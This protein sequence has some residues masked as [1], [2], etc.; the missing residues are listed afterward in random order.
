MIRL[1][2]L[3]I[4]CLLAAPMAMADIVINNGDAVGEGFNDPTT[5]TAAGGNAAHTL[6]QAR[7]NAFRHAAMLVDGMVS[8]T[9]PIHVDATMDP[10]FGDLTSAVLGGA[11]PLSAYINTPNLPLTNTLYV[12]A[13]ANAYAGSDQDINK[14]DIL[15]R[16]NSDVDG[17]FVLGTTHWYYGL[18]SSPTPVL[19]FVTTVKHEIIHGLGFLT[20]VDSSGKRL[21]D[22][23]DAYMMHLE[24]HDAVT[25]DFPSMTDEERKDAMIDDGNLHWIGPN[26]RAASSILTDG[27][28]STFGDHVKI[29]APNPYEPGSSTSHFDISLSPND[30]MEPIITNNPEI[31]LT[32]A[33]LKDIGWN[34]TSNSPTVPQADLSLVAADTS[35]AGQYQITVTNNDATNDVPHTTVTLAIPSN[36]NITGSAPSQGFC[37]TLGSLLRCNLGTLVASQTANI[38]INLIVTDGSVTNLSYNVSSPYFD[39]NTANNTDEIASSSLPALSI[40]S[41][42]ISEGDSGTQMLNVNVSL[43]LTAVDVVTVDYVTEDGS[44]TAGSDYNTTSGSLNIPAGTTSVSIPV[45]IIGD[46]S[47]EGNETFNLR[48]SN[49]SS[50]AVLGQALATVTIVEN[51]SA[52]SSGGGGGGSMGLLL[53]GL[54]PILLRRRNNLQ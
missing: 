16:F 31:I 43:S 32:A 23:N 11:S 15:A 40:A 8:S 20:F 35:T 45:S 5:T 34:I 6:G 14:S 2:N 49:I 30:L 48:L 46:T 39:T 44:A 54:L 7:L 22:L 37:S 26:V 33:L 41:T 27:K 3:L 51:D 12:S 36:I 29:Y 50:N 25:T 19:D 24:D 10:L 21:N 42:S 9:V 52:P 13:L 38:M 53:I 1:S 18:V 47:Y 4:P 17:D 28:D